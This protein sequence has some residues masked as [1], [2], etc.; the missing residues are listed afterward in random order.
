MNRLNPFNRFLLKI[1]GVCLALS[2]LLAMF[3]LNDQVEGT[4]NQAYGFFS[5]L[6]YTLFDNPIQSIGNFMND[7]SSL[8]S[9]KAENERLRKQIDLLEQFQ[10][11]LDEAY[12][13]IEDLKVLNDLKLSMSEYHLIAA[14]V[15]NR[16][17]DAF[18]HVLGL[19]VGTLD[20]V[21]LNDAVISSTGLIGKI[22]SITSNSCEVL[23]LTTEEE[24]NKV[25]VKIRITQ[26]DTAEALLEYY[27]VN[28]GSYILSLLETNATI[29]EGMTVI[30]SGLGE[31]YPSGLLVGTVSKVEVQQSA[32]GVKVY[33][34]PAADFA[35]INYVAIVKRGNL[36]V[37]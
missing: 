13:D 26:T 6:R 7:F 36:N 15:I 31:T 10:A 25:S 30:S 35:H 23:L 27:D 11:R 4:V 14:L 34:T 16:T 33:V 19:N 22:T 20:G 12:R 9:L 2:L 29:N 37:D 8:Y 1:V 24:L 17:P 18:N 21:E 3:R 32:G 5:S 28:S